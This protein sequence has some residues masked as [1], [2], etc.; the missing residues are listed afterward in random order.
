MLLIAADVQYSHI[1]VY[2]RYDDDDDDR[3]TS[4]YKIEELRNL[5][6]KINN[7]IM[8]TMTTMTMT[9]MTTKTT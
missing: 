1:F 3:H 8:T 7:T 9:T 6:G 5:D 2:I 4:N